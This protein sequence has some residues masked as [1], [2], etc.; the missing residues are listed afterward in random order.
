MRKLTTS[1]EKLEKE[2]VRLDNERKYQELKIN[3]LQEQAKKLTYSEDTEKDKEENKST[4]TKWIGST[5]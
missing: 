5:R 2:V 1:I 3:E 4:F